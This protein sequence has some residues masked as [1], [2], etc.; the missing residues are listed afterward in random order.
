LNYDVEIKRCLA[1][2]D[3][4]ALR[5]AEYEQKRIVLEAKKRVQE[6]ESRVLEL[7]V[8]IEKKQEELASLEG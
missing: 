3:I 1:E 6:A 2:K 5:A 8:Q 4:H 7:L